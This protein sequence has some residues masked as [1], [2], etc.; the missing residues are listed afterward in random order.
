MREVGRFGGVG[1]PLPE[2]L[3][4]I[5]RRSVWDCLGDEAVPPDAKRRETTRNDEKRRETTGTGVRR[6]RAERS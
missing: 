3:P 5:C 4:E 2:G 6:G 1:P